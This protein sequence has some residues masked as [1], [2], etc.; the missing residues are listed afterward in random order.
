MM[1]PGTIVVAG[2]RGS[3]EPSS[4]DGGTTMWRSFF[5]A[6]GIFACV[7]G[8]EML[9]VDSAVVMP[10]DGR[11]APQTVTA[12]DWAPWTLLSVG[13]VTILQFCTLQPKGASVPQGRGQGAPGHW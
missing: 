6:A 9:V 5:L 3:T 12:P 10:V 2:P 1:V 7:V 4:I 11:G 8:V 13:A